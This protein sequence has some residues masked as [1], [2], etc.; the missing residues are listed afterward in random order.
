VAYSSDR[1]RASSYLAGISK[2]R[3]ADVAI[4]R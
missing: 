2:V 1:I 3:S 4:T